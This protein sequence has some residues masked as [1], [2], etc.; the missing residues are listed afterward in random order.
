MK[1]NYHSLRSDKAQGA[2]YEL[3]FII[4]KTRTKQKDI[5]AITDIV[6]LT[7]IGF[8]NELMKRV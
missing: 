2:T 5:V 7:H 3:P 6:T 1:L 4:H 8:V